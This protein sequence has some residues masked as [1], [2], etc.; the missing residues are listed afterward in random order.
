MSEHDRDTPLR[1]ADAVRLGFPHGG[2]TVAGLRREGQRGN[3]R[4]WRIA[5]KDFTSLAAISEMMDRCH[6]TP[7]L[8][9][10]NFVPPA[11][12]ERQLGS[13]TTSGKSTAL[14]AA[15]AIFAEHK[16]RSKPS[17][18]KISRRPDG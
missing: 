9:S 7:N 5:N 2:I 10:S 18:R 16:R 13:S 4:M 12:I 1:L 8:Q 3:L 6:V 15:R 17:L 14:A 11:A